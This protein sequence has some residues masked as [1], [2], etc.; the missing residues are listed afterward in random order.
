LRFRKTGRRIKLKIQQRQN[1]KLLNYSTSSFCVSTGKK[2]YLF[3]GA[4][5]GSPTVYYFNWEDI[6]CIDSRSSAIKT[7]ALVFAPE[8]RSEAYKALK[9]FDWETTIIFE[10]TIDDIIVNPTIENLEKV[11]AIRDIHT[12]ERFRGKMLSYINNGK[13]IDSRFID[14]V[15]ERFKEINSGVFNSKLLL[16]PEIDYSGS[17]GIDVSELKEKN[18]AMEQKLAEMESMMAKIIKN[19]KETKDPVR[20][21]AGNK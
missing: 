13:G 16:K 15:N 2:E 1:I 10:E 18:R 5:N 20:P 14:I 19:N 8:D 12:I 6:E 7:G 21:E 11:L 9:K 17:A 4:K 3:D